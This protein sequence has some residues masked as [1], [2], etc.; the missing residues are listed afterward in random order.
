MYRA[1]RLMLQQWV[2]MYCSGMD[3]LWQELGTNN[4]WTRAAAN[5]ISVIAK[6][7]NTVLA[8]PPHPMPY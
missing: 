7:N 1:E 3:G 6:Y 8:R 5:L 2:V 4:G